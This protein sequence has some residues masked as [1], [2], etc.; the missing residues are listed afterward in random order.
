MSTFRMYKSLHLLYG[1]RALCRQRD[2]TTWAR[3]WADS[4]ICQKCLARIPWAMHQA[5]QQGGG[6]VFWRHAR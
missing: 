5:R 3:S 1:K 6:R 2:A 4:P